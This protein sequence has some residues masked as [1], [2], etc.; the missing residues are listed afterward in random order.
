M[1]NFR[2]QPESK[3]GSPDD[4]VAPS[5][6]ETITEAKSH[7]PA[8]LP[9]VQSDVRALPSLA[10]VGGP[11]VDEAYGGSGIAPE[12]PVDKD[13]MGEAIVAALKQV[14]DPEIPVNIY[15]LGLIYGFEID[16]DANVEISMTLTAPGCP[17]A[18]YMVEQVARQVGEVSGVQRSHVTLTWSPPWT[19]YRMTEA[20]MLEL[21]L[22]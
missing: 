4:E 7:A 3:S 5:S 15:D 10:D 20:A 16:D 12:G 22:L 18:G 14:Y 9:V 8:G 19:K 1:T 2:A 21:G 13:A 11:E 17:V 6:S